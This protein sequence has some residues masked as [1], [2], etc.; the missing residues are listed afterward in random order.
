VLGD[1]G[2]LGVG[3]VDDLAGGHGAFAHQ[4]DR[5]DG[6]VVLD[7]GDLQDAAEQDERLLARARR[8]VVGGRV[9]RRRPAP[10]GG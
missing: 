1:Q 8:V 2:D 7:L 9:R 6:V 3:E 4:H 10:R 5:V